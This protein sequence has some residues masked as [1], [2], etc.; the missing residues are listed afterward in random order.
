MAVAV[1]I[2]FDE[3]SNSIMTFNGGFLHGLDAFHRGI[4]RLS[5]S[6]LHRARGLIHHA[7]HF[8][9]GVTGDFANTFLHLAAD[10]AH[11]SGNSIIG[12]EPPLLWDT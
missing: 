7:C 12:H 10:I 3:I 11:C 1:W 6:I 9:L 4:H 5:V 2:V 8:A